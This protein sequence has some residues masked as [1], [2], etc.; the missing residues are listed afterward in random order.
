MRDGPLHLA[1]PLLESLPL[2]RAAGARVWLKLEAL[3]PTGSFKIRGIGH[4]CQVHA[5]QGRR[6]F[7]ASSGGNAGRAVAYAGRRLGVPVTVVVPESTTARARRGIEDEGAH[8]IVR[9]ASWLEAHEHA[10]TLLAPDA[11]Y[12]HPFD[13]PLLWEGHASL[14]REVLDAGL[15]P[16]VVV[17]SVGGGGLLCGVAQGLERA[18]RE[19]VRI[20]TAETRGAESFQRA[21]Q[22]GRVVELDAITSVATSLGARRVAEQAL[23]VARRFEVVPRV[24][25]DRQAV[26]ACLRFADDERVLVEP[27]CGAA[28][29]LAY[30]GD[31]AL[32][33]ARDVLLIVCGG[34]GVGYPELVAMKETLRHR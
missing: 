3:Q 9:G 14:V 11:A 8:V 1:T 17:L 13:D 4:A 16:D 33:G 20:V 22:A 10:R 34:A 24:V 6:R 2:G 12:I 19:R 18:G 25:S 32:R 5:A 27:A 21:V 28:L 15:E 7:V 29:A 26:D 30:A 23:E 31:D